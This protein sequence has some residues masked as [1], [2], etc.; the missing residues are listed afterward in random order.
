MLADVGHD[1]RVAVGDAPE[2][3]DHVRRIQVPVVG[4][5]LDVA[6]R[7]VALE[8]VDVRQP[9][10]AIDLG[11]ARH[12][13]RRR[14]APTSPAIAD[15]DADVLVELGADRCRRGSSCAFGA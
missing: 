12:P 13:A 3:V 6:D 10:R 1:D 8:L 9:L 15:V 7:R 14:T 2:V 4:Q 5:V 11:H